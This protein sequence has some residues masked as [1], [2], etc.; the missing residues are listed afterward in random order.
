MTSKRYILALKD[1][2]LTFNFWLSNSRIRFEK[3]EK[4]SFLVT[5]KL[6]NFYIIFITLATAGVEEINCL[7]FLL[8]YKAPYI[9]N[10][11]LLYN[12]NDSTREEI[13]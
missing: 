6:N 10:K 9:I 4:L 12:Q 3:I 1:F 13:T 8:I 5:K 7:T 2:S 11:I